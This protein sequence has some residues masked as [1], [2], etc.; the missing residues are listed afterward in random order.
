MFR[1]LRD[2]IIVKRI[3]R[4]LTTESGIV[5][6]ARS[7]DEPEKA[8]VIAIGSEVTDIA[9]GD[10][11]LINWNAAKKIGDDLYQMNIEHAIAVFE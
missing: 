6:S 7:S 9:V 1:P 5:L 3:D 11:L 4:D 10:Q 2:N 8:E